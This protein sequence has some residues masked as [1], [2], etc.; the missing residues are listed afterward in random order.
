MTENKLNQI[1]ELPIPNWHRI[2]KAIY[3]CMGTAPVIHCCGGGN[4]KPLIFVRIDNNA[5]K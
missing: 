1:S 3:S 4:M 2:A 5:K